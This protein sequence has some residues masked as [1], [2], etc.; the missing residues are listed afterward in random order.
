MRQIHAPL[1]SKRRAGS[2]AVARVRA[3]AMHKARATAFQSFALF[4]RRITKRAA[5]RPAGMGF[6]APLIARRPALCSVYPRESIAA[7]PMPHR[8]CRATTA[9]EETA[10]R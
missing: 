5:V 9:Q 6:V 7:K 8:L 2:E 3:G 4:A 10:V 1:S